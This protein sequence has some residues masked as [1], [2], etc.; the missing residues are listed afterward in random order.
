MFWRKSFKLGKN[1]RINLTKNGISSVSCKTSKHTRLG[2]TKKGQVY[3]SGYANGLYVRENIGKVKRNKSKQ[4]NNS[5]ERKYNGYKYDWSFFNGKFRKYYIASLVI[6]VV[7]IINWVVFLL[8]A[9]NLFVGTMIFLGK[10]I[11]QERNK[12]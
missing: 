9:L 12:K 11:K 1:V 10:Y 3:G 4:Q 2:V 5:T 7:S 6:T 8:A